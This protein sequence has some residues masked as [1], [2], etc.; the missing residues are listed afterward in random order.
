MEQIDYT[1]VTADGILKDCMKC[2][3]KESFSVLL[4]INE[5]G[6]VIAYNDDGCYI[7]ERN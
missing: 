3:G 5:T 2:K 4:F 6:E 1:K 7:C